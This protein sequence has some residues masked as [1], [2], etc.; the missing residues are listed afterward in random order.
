[1]LLLSQQQRGGCATRALFELAAHD[2]SSST[3]S[4]K[5]MSSMGGRGEGQSQSTKVGMLEYIA[6]EFFL[7]YLLS[8]LHVVAQVERLV[9]RL[10]LDIDNWKSSIFTLLFLFAPKF[11]EPLRRD[12]SSVAT[13]STS[14]SMLLRH[15]ILQEQEKCMNEESDL[16][17]TAS[18]TITHLPSSSSSTT[19]ESSNNNNTGMKDEWGHFAD[20]QDELA[21]EACFIPSCAVGATKS[22][23]LLPPVATIASTP[24]MV[25]VVAQQQQGLHGGLT[26]LATLTEEDDEEDEDWSF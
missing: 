24:L 16:L 25:G 13:F 23:T 15:A 8:F 22:L 4:L 2:K 17:L 1:L 6:E 19:L 12:E 14:N 21:D 18:T 7:G 20:F 11:E 26:G 10:I 5:S 9:R 3:S